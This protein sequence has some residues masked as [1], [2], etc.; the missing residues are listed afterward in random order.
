MSGKGDVVP[1]RKSPIAR[2]TLEGR[3]LPVAEVL[4]YIKP[5]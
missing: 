5:G 1:L 3:A 4:S 2:S